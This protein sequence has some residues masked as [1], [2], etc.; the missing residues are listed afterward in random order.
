[1][2]PLMPFLAQHIGWVAAL[3]T[4]SVVAFTGALLWLFVRVDRP[5]QPQTA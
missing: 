1:V 4:G 5:F 3:S 2:A